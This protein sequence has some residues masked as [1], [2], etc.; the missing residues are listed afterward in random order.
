MKRTKVFQ[1]LLLIGVVGLGVFMIPNFI[2]EPAYANPVTN[3]D[4]WYSRPVGYSYSGFVVGTTLV[5][6]TKSYD[7]PTSAPFGNDTFAQINYNNAPAASTYDVGSNT[8]LSTKAFKIPTNRTLAGLPN[9]SI[10][11]VQVVITWA[12]NVSANSGKTYQFWIQVGA[13]SFVSLLGPQGTVQSKTTQVMATYG[14]TKPA[15]L[16][17]GA[18]TWTN[19]NQVV[20]RVSNPSGGGAK[21]AYVY[22][23]DIKLNVYV[24]SAPRLFVSPANVTD[25]SKVVG[26]TFTVY[27]EMENISYSAGTEFKL[28]YDP[29]V[30]NITSTTPV[31]PTSPAEDQ[32]LPADFIY[33][34]GTMWTYSVDRTK[35]IFWLSYTSGPLATPPPPTFGSGKVAQINFQVLGLGLTTLKLYDSIQGRPGG[36]SIPCDLSNGYFRNVQY[37]TGVGYRTSM[38]AVPPA[39]T[40]N[41]PFTIQINITKTLTAQSG[42]FGVYS[43]EFNMTYDKTLINA[44]AIWEGTFFSKRVRIFS[45]IVGV[46][47]GWVW[48][49]STLNGD[50]PGVWG[51]GTLATVD[52]D[53]LG[54]GTSPLNFVANK[55]RLTRIDYGLGPPSPQYNL[56]VSPTVDGTVAVS[57]GV[58]EF[59]LGGAL[60]IALI[61]VIVFVWWKVRRRKPVNAIKG[62]QLKT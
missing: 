8:G 38:I 3:T 45:Q 21:N 47:K 32:A 20:I 57:T 60:E 42:A 36:G 31:P 23:F 15:G 26:S 59:P 54:T 13:S 50:L 9:P 33:A 1:L 39:G 46:N 30:L 4:V 53:I 44:T 28:R 34:T 52:F 22:V 55:E 35:G 27:V 11:Q 10:Q 29:E 14:S 16:G 40:Q 56:P 43:W 18:W 49:N 19:F 48:A 61:P 6:P 24:K 25:T 17:G 7:T 51:N 41:A 37:E 12:A 58:P 62:P 2:G 5:Y